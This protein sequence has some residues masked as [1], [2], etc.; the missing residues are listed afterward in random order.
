MTTMTTLQFHIMNHNN[1]GE[2]LLESYTVRPSRSRRNRWMVTKDIPSSTPEADAGMTIL[3]DNL[4]QD[5]A[6]QIARSLR[7]QELTRLRAQ[8]YQVTGAQNH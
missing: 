5:M 3:R 6:I 7:D 4:G 1:M 2:W 8:G